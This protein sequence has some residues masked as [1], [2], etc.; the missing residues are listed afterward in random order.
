MPDKLLFDSTPVKHR[1]SQS[2]RIRNIGNA[3]ANVKFD[4]T[5][6]FKINPS[7]LAL[8]SNET[9]YITCFF[10]PEED[11]S[12]SGVLYIS[13]DTGEK[14]FVNLKGSGEVSSV[15]LSTKTILVD[16]T[17]IGLLNTKT[18]Q[19]INDADI[20]VF[21]KWTPFTN[22]EEESACENLLLNMVSTN[23][24]S[25]KKKLDRKL[26]FWL[27]N[28]V[29]TDGEDIRL[30]GLSFIP[31]HFW[32]VLMNT[33]Q[34]FLTAVYNQNEFD[35][36]FSS[37]KSIK[38]KNTSLVPINFTIRIIAPKSGVDELFEVLK[39]NLSQLTLQTTVIGPD[40]QLSLPGTES[41]TWSTSADDVDE[42]T[43][44]PSSGSLNAMSRVE[45]SVRCTPKHLGMH[46]Y[47]IAV[48]I[49]GVGVGD[50]TL[51]VKV[52]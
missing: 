50:I 35:F 39:P 32:E 33:V 38:L 27:R 45:L 52:E 31:P 23:D 1:R 41:E 26:G 7:F 51:P 48:D 2:V 19:I 13:Y 21:F 9:A 43:I 20:P 16:D 36:G 11:V 3:V 8:K 37:E 15:C 4:T 30:Y 44:Q 29:K 5:L 18:F 10:L 34:S 42:F 28:F 47:T 6:P 40:S 46:T 49:V 14:S 24:F 25:K 12:Y 22:S 17:Y